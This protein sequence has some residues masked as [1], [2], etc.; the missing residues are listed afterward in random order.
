MEKHPDH[1]A[2]AARTAF[3]G[4]ELPLTEHSEPAVAAPGHRDAV[5]WIGRDS[6]AFGP[7]TASWPAIVS[8]LRRRPRLLITVAVL[9][10]ALGAALWM[11]LASKPPALVPL[12]DQRS[13]PLVSVI[14]PGL[15]PV[16]TQVMVTGAVEAR[17]DLPIGDGGQ[18]GRIVAVY[19]Q[20]G[21]HVRKGQVLAQLDD[22]VLAPQVN[23]LNASLA[24]ARAQARLSA[25]E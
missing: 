2:D 6:G 24:K 9:G 8:G 5:T 1:Q 12:A 25:A 18:S 22:S 15:Q 20:A 14:V 4:Q 23:E 7:P 21:D 10:V 19:A 11:H 16:S 3:T 13:V 17:H